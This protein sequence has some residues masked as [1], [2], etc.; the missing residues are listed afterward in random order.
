[1]HVLEDVNLAIAHEEGALAGAHPDTTDVI[2]S[3]HLP[4]PEA[5]YP[6]WRDLRVSTVAY[7]IYRRAVLLAAPPGEHC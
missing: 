1:M 4:I 3:C 5:L 2:H 6:R 7:V